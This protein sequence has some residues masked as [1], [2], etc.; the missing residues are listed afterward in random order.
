M[1]QVGRG[2]DLGQEA[3]AA[4]H[5][6]ELGAQ[7]LQRDLAVVLEIVGEIN[8]RHA[9]RAELALEA[10]AGGEGRG[11]ASGDVSHYAVSSHGPSLTADSFFINGINAAAITVP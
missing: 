3:L 7:D 2:L 9:A 5:G 1:L 4:D 6:R 10:V 8:G 11:E